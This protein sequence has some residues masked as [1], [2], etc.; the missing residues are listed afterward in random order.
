[1]V[2]THTVMGK[3]IK[4]RVATRRRAVGPV[5]IS[6]SGREGVPWALDVGTLVGRFADIGTHQV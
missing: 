3:L 1:V 2:F 4:D 5:M 6:R